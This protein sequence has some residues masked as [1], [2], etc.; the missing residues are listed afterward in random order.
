MNTK[1][2]LS[3]IIGCLGLVGS[4]FLNGDE[5]KGTISKISLGFVIGGVLEFMVYL[6]ENRKR[7]NLL[8]TTIYKRNKPVRI[9]VA[10]LFRIELNGQYALIKRHKKDRIGYQ[11]IGGAYKYLH[12]ENREL[13]DSLGIEPCT[14]I[15]RDEDTEHDLR[16]IIKKRKNLIAF[17]KWFES[18]K[19]R[20]LDPWREFY[21]ELIEPGLLPANL[22]K[23]IKYVF[24]RKHEEGIIP[25]PVFPVDEYRY[26]DVF[27]LRF[28][29]EQQKQA[30]L[31]L[32]QSTGEVIFVTAD[33]I[34][35]GA[36]NKGLVILPHSFKI[37]PKC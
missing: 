36:T 14:H 32:K 22:F 4:Y 24:I 2:I 11:P 12:E 18:K 25:S 21:E 37:L 3:F 17:L 33:E 23:H 29:T 13:F 26:A 15:E 31:D 27:E 8:I 34:R 30:F 1:G 28:E 20:E 35:K 10:Y 9:T 16:L 19:N 7:W 6:Y 5:P